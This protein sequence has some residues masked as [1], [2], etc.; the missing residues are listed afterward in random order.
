MEFEFT[1]DSRTGLP[2]PSSARVYPHWTG[3]GTANSA[4]ERTKP[5]YSPRYARAWTFHESFKGVYTSALE[6]VFGEANLASSKEAL[7]G[8]MKVVESWH[9]DGESQ[10]ERLTAQLRSLS[11]TDAEGVADDE[12]LRNLYIPTLITLGD[13]DE[14]NPAH[15]A[16]ELYELLPSAEL[17]LMPNVSH[18]AFVSHWVH[19]SDLNCGGCALAT[20]QFPAV[21]H[22]FLDRNRQ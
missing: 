20:E 13:R 12:E 9:P 3:L 2:A 22:D 15:L 6:K 7:P 17:W 5:A 10:L 14:V 8:Y 16:L 19:P 4:T 11:K 21:L 18:E 1:I